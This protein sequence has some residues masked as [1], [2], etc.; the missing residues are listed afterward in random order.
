V[1]ALLAHL[2]V[3]VTRDEHRGEVAQ[4]APC[5]THRELR[6]LNDFRHFAMFDARVAYL[7]STHSAAPSVC[8][9]HI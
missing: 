1:P 9:E 8:N 3:A 4:V 6:L 5:L 7:Y 2:A